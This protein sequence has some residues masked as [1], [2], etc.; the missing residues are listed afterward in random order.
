MKIISYAL[1]FII[2]F[3]SCYSQNNSEEH[4]KNNYILMQNL[5]GN[6]KIY[7]YKYAGLSSFSDEESNQY[8]GNNLLIDKDSLSIFIFSG[9]KPKYFFRKELSSAYI[10]NGYKCDYR[11]LGFRKYLT[12]CKIIYYD[13]KENEE[14]NYDIFVLSKDE[15]ICVFEGVF[16]YAKKVNTKY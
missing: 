2:S 13:Y 5:L 3:C 14:R 4:T 7:K 8:I 6:W 16:F 10:A 12:I 1:F 15:I 9:N 11:K